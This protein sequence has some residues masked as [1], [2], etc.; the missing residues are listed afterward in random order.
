M[1]MTRAAGLF[2]IFTVRPASETELY[3][4]WKKSQVFS[5]ASKEF[6]QE[7]EKEWKETGT[8]YF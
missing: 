3:L 7:I 5:R 4:I 2:Y 8:E 6:L 1:S